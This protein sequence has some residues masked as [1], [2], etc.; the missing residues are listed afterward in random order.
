[1]SPQTSIL[2]K[3][4]PKIYHFLVKYCNLQ[5]NIGPAEDSMYFAIR[6]TLSALFYVTT[7]AYLLS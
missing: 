3:S 6:H 2:L 4:S 1:M 7:M 5:K